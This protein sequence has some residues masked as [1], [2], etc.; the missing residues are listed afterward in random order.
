MGNEEG[1]GEGRLS[2]IDQFSLGPIGE[3]KRGHD[4]SRGGRDSS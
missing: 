2:R 1:G 4:G 3:S